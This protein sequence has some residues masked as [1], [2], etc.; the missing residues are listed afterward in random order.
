MICANIFSAYIVNI[1]NNLPNLVVDAL[2]MHLNFK[3]Q[4]D[5]LWLHQAVTCDFT[6]S[7]IGTPETDQ[8]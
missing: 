5:K 1:W 7:L 6:A 3:A 8:N 4:L 2:L